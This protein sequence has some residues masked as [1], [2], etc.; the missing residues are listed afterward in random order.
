MKMRLLAGLILVLLQT[1]SVNAYEHFD[2]LNVKN[3]KI[4]S[5]EKFV[6]EARE[7]DIII[8]GEIHD[9]KRHHDF[10]LKVIEELNKRGLRLAIA[11]EMFRQEN[12]KALDDF[13]IGKIPLNDFLKAYYENWS[14]PWKLYSSIFLFAKDKKIP[15]LGINIPKEITEKVAE[16]GF[17]SLSKK[18]LEKLPPDVLCDVD[19]EYVSFIKKIFSLHGKGEKE[20]KNFCEAQVLWDK[21]MAFYVL[22]YMKSN[23][24]RKVI[25]LTGAVHAGKSAITAQI[26]KLNKN[27]NVLTVIPQIYGRIEPDKIT[28][29]DADY[30]LYE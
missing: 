4:I 8:I 10:Q 19:D 5:V 28:D 9:D 6:Q 13:I 27:I 30:M 12:Q 14:A 2:I 16:N 7:A 21:S 22:D 24:G 15:L 23:P 17:F 3:R 18:D 29:K 25:I 11:M 20:F 26:K 1:L